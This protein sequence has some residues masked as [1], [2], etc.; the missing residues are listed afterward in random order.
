MSASQCSYPVAGRC[1]Q[2]KN[3]V[4]ATAARRSAHKSSGRSTL[5]LGGAAMEGQGNRQGWVGANAEHRLGCAFVG[6]FRNG[7]GLLSPELPRFQSFQEA[8]SPV[9][10]C[11]ATAAL[12][13]LTPL[14]RPRRRSLRSLLSSSAKA[15]LLLPSGGAGKCKVLGLI[16]RLEVELQLQLELDTSV[17]VC[18][19][20]GRAPLGG[21]R[22]KC[23]STQKPVT[24]SADQDCWR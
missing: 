20:V 11:S 9:S 2:V 7:G 16:L 19:P 8:H 6:G 22:T 23:V 21:T 3:L 17:S 4:L 12:C 1:S 14:S 24:L 18:A 10:L 13:Q 5:R 15:L